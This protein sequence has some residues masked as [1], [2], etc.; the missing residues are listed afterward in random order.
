MN[1]GFSKYTLFSLSILCM[2]F[3]GLCKAENIPIEVFFKNPLFRSFS[4]SPDGKT[5]AVLADVQ[6]YMNLVSLDLETRE[7]R[8]ITGEKLDIT[9]FDWVNSGRLVY[10]LNQF[11][12][13]SK[14]RRYSGG[15]F[16]VDKMG[17]DVDL[18]VYPFGASTGGLART[19]GRNK[20]LIFEHVYPQD[21]DYILVTNYNRRRL[22][23]DLFLLNVEN[24]RLKRLENNPGEVGQFIFDPDGNPVAGLDFTDSASV[25]FF[26]KT[27]ESGE[28]DLLKEFDQDYNAW[29]PYV[30]ESKDEMLIT[31]FDEGGRDS[32]YRLNLKTAEISEEPVFQDPVYDVNGGSIRD[33]KSDRVVGITYEAEKPTA[34]YFDPEY[35]KLQDLLDQA[36]PN[37]YNRIT[38]T[39]NS[40]SLAI[41]RSISDT[42]S[43]EYYLLKTETLELEMLGKSMPW[44]DQVDLVPQ[45]PIV[46]EARDSRTIHGYLY[47]PNS[48][49]KG[50]PV[51]L[52]VYP[53]GGPWARDTWG[54]RSWFDLIPQ[55]LANRGFAVIQMN[56]RGSTGYGRDHLKSS[57]KNL[58][59]MHNDV[60]D[61]ARWAIKEGYA[62]KDHLGIMGASWG[63]YATMTAL[64]KEPDMFEFGVN[65]FGVVDL[66]KHIRSYLNDWDRDSAYSYWLHR[67]G[68]ID[69]SEDL[70]NLHEWS[71]IN[72]IENI[73][74]PVFV[75]H[76]LRD[77]NVHIDQSRILVNELEKNG[78]EFV[79]VFR[80]DEAHSA[81]DE[82]N[83]LDLYSQLDEF[84]RPFMKQ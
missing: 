17:K 78:K 2:G 25:K 7:L 48:Y 46:Y 80:E 31:M 28:W 54:I 44:L 15:L 47:L 66:E 30:V 24:R 10:S 61:A 26:I 70:E 82:S 37:A 65:I 59:A 68:D 53:H 55:W 18:L 50:K 60:I 79:K 6:G 58:E 5:L 21:D 40:G 16:T 23:P 81:F 71:P 13:G 3:S 76:G 20:G 49:E 32:L 27:V 39:D 63:G 75:Y 64:V 8:P 1:K 36:I 52:V 73:E 72:F 67:I 4:I 74:A 42:K 11:S 29:T 12:F 33:F 83:R 77:F 51:P 41:V 34:V 84:L 43:P 69:D 38:N 9:S 19:K 14:A 56:F 62:D 35:Q 57:F 45:K 22:H